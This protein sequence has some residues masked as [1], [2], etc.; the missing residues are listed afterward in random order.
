MNTFKQVTKD[1]VVEAAI[2]WWEMLRP[3]VF[4]RKQHTENP[5]INTTSMA[6]RNLAEA[7]GALF[8]AGD[9]PKDCFPYEL[10]G[11]LAEAA[12][13][14][15]NTSGPALG[16][17]LQKLQKTTL[18]YD[19]AIMALGKTKGLDEPP[20]I[21]TTKGLISAHGIGLPRAILVPDIEGIT[22]SVR[23]AM[24]RRYGKPRHADCAKGLY[25]RVPHPTKKSG[26]TKA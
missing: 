24:T 6:E 16:S 21:R 20:V 15:L 19:N 18:A 23:A 22:D 7:I 12:G 11:A 8:Q 10:A 26:K 5:A 2:N 1:R 9:A 13:E 25:W 4:N 14:V 3:C 17:A